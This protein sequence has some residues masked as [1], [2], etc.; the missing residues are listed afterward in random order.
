MRLLALLTPAALLGL[1]FEI[2]PSQIRQGGVVRVESSAP[3]ATARLNERVVPLF[4]QSQGTWLGL[5]PVSANDEPGTYPLEVLD[6]SGAV[7]SSA[8]LS[9]GDAGFP[10]QNIVLGKSKSTLKPSP[11]EMKTVTAFRDTVSESMEWTGSF[12]RPVATCMTS[13]FGVRRLHNGKRTGRYH[14]GLDLRGD[15]TTAIAA[16]APGIVRLA[17]KFN[18]HGGTVGIDHGQGVTSMYLHMSKIS[19]A[20]GAAVQTGDIIGNV[21]STGRSTAPHLHWAV[22][23]HGVPVDPSQWTEFDPC[24]PKKTSPTRTRRKS[25]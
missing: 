21:G 15:T 25:R 2:N 16:P 7:L 23:V 9:I 20:E 3:A 13:P 19:V 8:P 22:H 17:K 5:M 4:R 18:I 12:S 1:G 24:P 14:G 10:E 11:G 6:G